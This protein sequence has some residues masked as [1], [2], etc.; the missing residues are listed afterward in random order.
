MTR[1][2]GAKCEVCTGNRGLKIVA[3]KNEKKPHVVCSRHV[4]LMAKKLM[5]EFPDAETKT[6]SGEENTELRE[7]L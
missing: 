6:A 5:E 3:N 1:R 7:D 4:K 2:T